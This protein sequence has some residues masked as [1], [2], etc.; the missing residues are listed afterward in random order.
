MKKIKIPG[1]PRKKHNR[2][3]IL[4]IRGVPKATREKFKKAAESKGLTQWELF[5]MVADS[6]E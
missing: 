5:C 2:N 6:I 4:F 3:E 1:K